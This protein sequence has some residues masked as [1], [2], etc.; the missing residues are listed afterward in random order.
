MNQLLKKRICCGKL[1]V[2]YVIQDFTTDWFKPHHEMTSWMQFDTRGILVSLIC[3]GIIWYE[4]HSSGLM[5]SLC[6]VINNSD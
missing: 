3:V 5:T 2:I 6:W 4:N 1:L